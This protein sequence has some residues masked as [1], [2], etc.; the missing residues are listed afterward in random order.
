MVRWEDYSVPSIDERDLPAEAEPD[1]VFG[2]LEALLADGKKTRALEKDF[3]DYIYNSA[4]LIVLR[5]PTLKLV[6]QPGTSA[7]QFKEECA[8]VAQDAY[9]VEADKLRAC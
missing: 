2:E 6:A 9:D 5:N 1:S 7:V 3:V 8:Q 4:A